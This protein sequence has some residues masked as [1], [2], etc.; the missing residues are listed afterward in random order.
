[1]LN[2]RLRFAN[3]NRWQR[4]W[5]IA[6]S[7]WLVACILITGYHFPTEAR[8]RAGWA[9]ASYQ[10]LSGDRKTIDA[11]DAECRSLSSTAASLICADD[12]LHMKYAYRDRLNGLTSYGEKQAQ[13]ERLPDQLFT[14]AEG[15]VLWA[16]PSLGLYLFAV[17]IS[18]AKKRVNTPANP[19][20][21]PA[22]TGD[23]FRWPDR[24][25]RKRRSGYRS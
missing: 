14:I 1:M 3:L 18:W 15:I 25:R 8:L 23:V 13:E 19:A 17:S 24:T 10:T 9:V 20:S 22:E 5:C 6:V 12:V 2:F 7:I 16:I 11:A 21:E 4:A